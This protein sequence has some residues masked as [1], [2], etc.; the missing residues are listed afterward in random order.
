ME[1][2]KVS[3][4]TKSRLN[5]KNFK[6]WGIN[7]I[8]YSIL[9]CISFLI[10]YPFI[11][12]IANSFKS[13][14]DLLD[15]TVVFIPKELS[16]NTIHLTMR[17]MH[18]PEALRNSFLLSLLV[19]ILQTLSS[20]VIGYGFARFKFPLKR[21]LFGLL[22]FTIIVPPQIIMTPLYMRFKE[23]DFFNVIKIITGYS[24]NIL[25]SFIPFIIL[26]LTGLGLKNGLYIYLIRQFF[27]NM[28]RELDDAAYIDGANE[29][30]VFAKI[31]LPNAIPIL[32][33]NFLLSFSWQWTDNYFTPLII[34]E[35][36]TLP[37]AI[38]SIANYLLYDIDPIVRSAMM[39]TGIILVILPILII[40]I[41]LQRFF[42]QGIERSG[43]VG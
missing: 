29:F 33:T 15:K 30:T 31:M 19:G 20:A 21:V 10:I 40:Y 24:P 37:L 18:Y 5:Y 34:Q 11:T 32:I 22:I 9:L 41:F 35:F 8:C 23:F 26:S 13:E 7:L 28:P 38:G 16:T 17:A 39:G 3:H 4:K 27:K 1:L 12:N 42:V 25:N 43:I 6:M 14:A 36:Y 2:N